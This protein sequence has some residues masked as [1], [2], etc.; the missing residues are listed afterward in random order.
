MSGAMIYQETL[1]ILRGL[2]LP[3][4]AETDVIAALEVAR[5]NSPL[6]VAYWATLQAK[7]ERDESIWRAAAVFFSFAAAN[8]ADDVSDGDCHYLAPAQAPGVQF[9]LQNLVFYCLMKTSIQPGTLRSIAQE[10]IEMGAGQQIEVST[11]SWNLE[12]AKI[13]AETI[14]GR[15]YAAYLQILW[16]ETK[17]ADQA[18]DWGQKLGNAAQISIDLQSNDARLLSMPP[19]DIRAILRWALDEIEEFKTSPIEML[20]SLWQNLAQPMIDW[21]EQSAA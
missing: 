11:E 3:E 5:P 8:L 20:S 15:Q 13:V 7:L 10:L 2:N 17:F 19:E 4:T 18:R 6:D 21:L 1:R 9:I 16:G 14:A 12:R